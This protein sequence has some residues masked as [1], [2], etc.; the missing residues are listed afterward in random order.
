MRPQFS[1]QAMSSFL[2]WFDHMLQDEGEAYI[3][4]SSLFYSIPTSYANR[5]AYG[6]PYR[7]FI[8]DASITGAT[9]FSGI[10]LNNT[11]VQ[12][13]T[14]GF[15]GVNYDLGQVYFTGALPVGTRVSGNYSLKEFNV[16]LTSEPE[17][18]ILFETK[19]ELRNK[20]SQ[21]PTGLP[22]N[23]KTYPIIYLK[24]N[25][26]SNEPFAFGGQDSTEM[27]VTAII[28]TDTQFA[29]DGITSL[30]EDRVRGYVPL[31]NQSE[32]PINNFGGLTSGT[33]NYTGIA[34]TKTNSQKMFIE[35]VNSINIPG[36]A[37]SEIQKQNPNVYVG[38]L[39][40]ELCAYRYP[41][42]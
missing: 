11:F 14:S 18:K 26:G 34:E 24:K 37:Y 22:S 36:M 20:V 13:G 32:M 27:A 39:E 23:V 28:L 41:R 35:R 33:Y 40:F 25:R 31:F 8:P 42:C 6:A 7:S 2:L 4:K 15:T 3:N 16:S 9:Q 21:T 10:Y 17:E 12:L 30:F 5:H 38:L 1:N 19:Y 29:I